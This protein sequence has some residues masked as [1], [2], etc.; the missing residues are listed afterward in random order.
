MDSQDETI[1][2]LSESLAIVSQ[3]MGHYAQRCDY[4]QKRI[5]ELEAELMRK[6]R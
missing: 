3:A 5:S 6:E 4:L 1:K 2:N